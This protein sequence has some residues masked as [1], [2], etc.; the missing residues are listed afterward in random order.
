[1][2]KI[3]IFLVLGLVLTG[4]SELIEEETIVINESGIYRISS[5]NQLE[6]EPQLD[7]SNVTIEIAPIEGNLIIMTV[8]NTSTGF[9]SPTW[10]MKT[11]RFTCEGG[12]IAE[13]ECVDD[14]INITLV[15]E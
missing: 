13:I 14:K 1:M 10:D 3:I 2:K 6:V 9:S 15:R 8:P 5:I 4:C 12:V 7:F 11:A